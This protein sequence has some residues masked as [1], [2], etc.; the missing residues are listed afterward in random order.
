MAYTIEYKYITNNQYWDLPN[1]TV[2]GFVQHSIGIGQE[3]ADVI[4]NNANKSSYAASF[5]ACVEPGRVVICA[6]CMEN[7]RV[8]KKCYHVGGSY[9]NTRIGVEMTEPNTIEYTSGSTYKDLDPEHSKDF[10]RRVTDTAAEFMA[11]LCI[12]HN[13]PV[14]TICTHKEAHDRG[15]GSDH[16]DPEHVWKIINY[17]PD[18]F[19][20]DV[21]RYID[22]KTGQEEERSWLDDMTEA[23]F[24]KLQK[25]QTD[26]ICRT[27]DQKFEE[28]YAKDPFLTYE[29]ISEVPDWSRDAVQW[30]LNNG[31]L[32][33]DGN[34]L[35]LAY[36]DM[37]NIVF[38]YRNEMRNICKTM[39]D[40]P[41][42]A[43]ASIEKAIKAGVI[44]GENA[45]G[46]LNLS[47]DLIRSLVIMDRAGL[48]DKPEKVEKAE[49]PAK[50]N[51]KAAKYNIPLSGGDK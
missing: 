9:N 51:K 26:L 4:V 42:Y 21:Q 40:V 45:D 46:D 14:S 3:S 12:Y 6:P 20:R 38:M 19:R 24:N 31:I 2:S 16:G 10:M 7:Y 48:F 18:D 28:L 49:A 33:G 5:H 23:E 50:A 15:A 39:A 32:K 17:T 37:K 25:E 43:K 47:Y 34:G 29:S 35:S 13:R 36:N 8:A 41:D 44:A 30:A 1:I 11:D 22:I 27:F